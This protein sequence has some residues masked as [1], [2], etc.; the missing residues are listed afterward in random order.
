MPKEIIICIC[1]F[2]LGVFCWIWGFGAGQTHPEVVYQD[3]IVYRDRID[4]VFVENK[5]IETKIIKVEA[6]YEEKVAD[7]INNDDS[8]NYVFFSEYIDNYERTTQDR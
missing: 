8:L 7:I 1:A 6:E 3:S 4:S 2:I 5:V